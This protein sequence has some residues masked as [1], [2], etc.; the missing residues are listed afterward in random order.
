[1][2]FARVLVETE[3]I[4]VIK[5]LHS[6]TRQYVIVYQLGGVSVCMRCTLSY[7]A[8]SGRGPSSLS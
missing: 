2:V 5:S 1:M 7:P 4:N 3:T 8:D 6:Q